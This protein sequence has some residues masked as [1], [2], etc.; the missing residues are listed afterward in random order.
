VSEIVAQ[1]GDNETYDLTVVDASGVA[2]D[3]TS[4]TLK[5]TIKVN[6]KDKHYIVQKTTGSG[7]TLLDQGAPATKGMA[8]IALLPADTAKLVAPK[9]LYFDV[10]MTSDSDIVTTVVDGDFSLLADITR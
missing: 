2:I 6:A 7:I 8:T 9:T 4:Y 10:E 1:R 5:F 3:L